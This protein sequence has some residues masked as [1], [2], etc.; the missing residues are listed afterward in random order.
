MEREG[1]VFGGFS[2]SYGLSFVSLEGTLE[3]SFT[4]WS[5]NSSVHSQIGPDAM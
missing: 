5:P 1:W 2:F 4:F 3:I